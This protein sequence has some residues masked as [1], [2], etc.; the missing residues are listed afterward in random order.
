MLKDG[1]VP[2]S[3]LSEAVQDALD[4]VA[5]QQ[6]ATGPTGATG[7][8]G[9][10]GTAGAIGATGPQGPA[11]P[12][13]A[14][15]VQG[16]TG[17]TGAAGGA[18]PAGATGA[19]GLQ[20]VAGTSG[21]TGPAG[22]GVP[23]AGTTGQLLAKSSDTDYATEWIDAP[24][25]AASGVVSV[26]VATGSEVR[27]TADTVLWIGGGTQP[28]NMANNDLWFSPNQPTDTEA[29]TEPTNLGASSITSTG[30]TLSWTA[31]T[32][33]V[34]VTAY[35]IFLDGVSH[36][37]VTGTSTSITGRSG[38]TTYACTVRARDAA[39]NWGSESDSYDVTTLANIGGEH[40]VYGSTPIAALS[41]EADTNITVASGFRV[42]GSGYSVKGARL[43]VPSGVSAPANCTMYLY[44]PSGNNAPNLNNPVLTAPI[45]IT[46]GQWNEVYFP[47]TQSVTS[48]QYF[49][50]GYMFAGGVLY[51]SK[52]TE[53]D[54]EI[55]ASDGSPL[56]V[57]PITVPTGRRRNYY[58]YNSDAGTGSTIGGQ[59]YGIDVIITED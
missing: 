30:F 40:T 27:P 44:T 3:A 36:K 23:S 43:Y 6:G 18:G 50:I 13:G 19:T 59:S 37:I 29:P 34:G 33:N 28:A 24:T 32:D 57:A 9:N 55:Q 22:A 53:G 11:G 56:Y 39:G 5:G 17:A 46:A 52:A 35:E 49:W 21:A 12:T 4:V 8:Q 38:N 54:A 2:K 47:S 42:D 25:V 31:A 41:G 58:R 45:T 7:P 14:V 10:P 1:S 51:L 16:V 48:G 20:G 26:L 15:G